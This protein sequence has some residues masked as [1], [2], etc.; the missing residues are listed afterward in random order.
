VL[1][2]SKVP[3]EVLVRST[4]PI[5][6]VVIDGNG[7]DGSRKVLHAV[8]DL[9]RQKRTEQGIYEYSFKSIIPSGS[10]ADLWRIEAVNGGGRKEVEVPNT[11]IVP[12]AR[13]LLE[14]VALRANRGRTYPIAKSDAGALVLDRPLP[15]GEL[16][17][18]GYVRESVQDGAETRKIPVQVWVNGFLQKPVLAGKA[19]ADGRRPFHAE[20][21]L[22]QR[23][24]NQIEVSIVDPDLPS[25]SANRT[26][27]ALSCSKPISGRRLYLL[28][29][30]VGAKQ[31]EGA[32]VRKRAVAAVQG[33][34]K[35]AR[36]FTTGSFD[37]GLIHEVLL[38]SAVQRNKVL[39]E[40]GRLGRNLRP[41]DVALIYYQGDV[42]EADDT[43]YLTTSATRALADPKQTE[44]SRD[45]LNRWFGNMTG[46]QLILLDVDRAVAADATLAKRNIKAVWPA[47]SHI[48]FFRFAWAPPEPQNTPNE[49]VLLTALEQATRRSSTLNQIDSRLESFSSAAAD[50][51][52]APLV[53]D[54]HL[55]KTLEGLDL[56]TASGV[57]DVG[58]RDRRR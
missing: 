50:R 1:P 19:Q 45:E 58:P 2:D 52:S 44:I 54:K 15:E 23:E 33:Q 34:A 24:N 3:V 38:G 48:A 56:G 39:F 53:Y 46:A 11:V 5:Q 4:S 13:V 55:T 41:S 20:I 49:S 43:F 40:I 22:T 26:K 27:I 25:E 28:V 35:S 16:V 37:Q 7:I 36:E 8:A 12:P 10:D 14:S 47:D 18:S 57:Q 21:T 9:E 30:A 31:T 29:V 17:L 32:E 42:R 6:D 51:Y